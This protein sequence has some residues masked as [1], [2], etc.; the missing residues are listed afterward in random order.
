MAF[1]AAIAERFGWRIPFIAVGAIGI[2]TALVVSL[3]LTVGV[4]CVTPKTPRGIIETWF[5]LGKA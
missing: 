1:G 5:G 4:S 2:V 3:A